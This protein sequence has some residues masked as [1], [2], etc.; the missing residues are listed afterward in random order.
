[1]PNDLNRVCLLARVGQDPEIRYTQSGSAIL[2]M[3][4]ATNRTW[5]QDGEKRQQ[6]HWHRVVI[7]GKLAQTMGDM[8][9]KG[10]RLYLEGSMETRSWDSDGGKRYT[11]ECV[12]RPY[13]GQVTLLS[14]FEA[15]GSGGSGD[16]GA[17]RASQE[18]A[19]LPAGDSFDDFD[20]DIPF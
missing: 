12:I 15:R 4:V 9:K 6:T 10:T 1:M 3:S 16:S 2:N 19:S 20:D 8:I 13:E 14:G 17:Q 11:T 7:F 5:K 18:A